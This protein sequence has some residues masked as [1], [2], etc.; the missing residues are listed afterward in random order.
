MSVY[1]NTQIRQAIDEGHILCHPFDPKHVSHASHDTVDSRSELFRP[2]HLLIAAL[3]SLV[4]HPLWPSVPT[5]KCVPA[6]SAYLNSCI[7]S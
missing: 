2:W 3:R 4:D 1:S 6:E 7:S 5:A